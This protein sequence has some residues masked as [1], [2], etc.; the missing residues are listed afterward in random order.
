L[1]CPGAG[2]SCHS[3]V[4]TGAGF[5]AGVKEP[6]GPTRPASANPFDDAIHHTGPGSSFFASQ[7]GAAVLPCYALRLGEEARFRLTFLPEVP[8]GTPDRGRTGIKADIAVLDAAIEG[9]VRAHPE[10]WF[11][12]HAFRPDR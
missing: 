9:V 5:A 11:M 8:V 2:P 3:G 7:T 12:L 4:P 6:S 10:Q 1:A